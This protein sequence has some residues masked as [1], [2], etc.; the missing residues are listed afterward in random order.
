MPIGAV[1]EGLPRSRVALRVSFF[2]SE[3]WHLLAAVEGKSPDRMAWVPVDRPRPP[4][5]VGSRGGRPSGPRDPRRAGGPLRPLR[6]GSVR[7]LDLS[8]GCAAGA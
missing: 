6:L 8:C 2:G 3:G 1:T 7:L 4:H 5:P